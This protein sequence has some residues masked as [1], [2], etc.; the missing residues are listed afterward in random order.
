MGRARTAAP[1]VIQQLAS[2]LHASPAPIGT[3]AMRG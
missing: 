3:L 1:I 2:Y